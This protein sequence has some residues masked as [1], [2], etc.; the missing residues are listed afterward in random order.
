MNR[1]EF[2]E[3]IEDMGFH[4]EYDQYFL[5]VL[6]KDNFQLASI[7]TFYKY[8]FSFHHVGLLDKGDSDISAFINLV[9]EFVLS[10]AERKEKKRDRFKGLCSDRGEIHEEHGV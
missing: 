4:I 10:G 1:E 2:F 7:S 8:Q 5:Y 6:D 3:K 9:T